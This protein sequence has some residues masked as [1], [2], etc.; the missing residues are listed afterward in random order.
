MARRS[1]RSGKRAGHRRGRYVKR[2]NGRPQKRKTESASMGLEENKILTL[3]AVE[4][5]PMALSEIKDSLGVTRRA[6]KVL[7]SQLA[8]L[9]REE[10]LTLTRQGHYELSESGQLTTG[11]ISMNPRGFGFVTP[12]EVEAEGR[13]AGQDIFIPPGNLETAMHGDRVLVRCFSSRRKERREGRVVAVLSRATNRLVGVF[14]KTS[15]NAGQVVPEDDRYPFTVRVSGKDIG[16][17]DNGDAVVVEFTSLIAGSNQPIGRIVEILGDPDSLV[18]QTEMTIRSRGLPNRFSPAVEEE[19]SRLDGKITMHK[20]RLDLREIPHVTIDGETARDFDDAVAVEVVNGGYRL[21]VSIADVSHYVRIGTALDREAYQRGTSVY[22]PNMVVPML[23][24][25]LSND[26]CSLVPEE[27]RYAFTAI[28]DFNAHGKRVGQTFH[29]SIIRSFHRLT[30]TKVKQVLVDHDESLVAELSAILPAL[31]TMAELAGHLEKMR[32]NRGSI[33]FE[34]PEAAIEIDEQGQIADIKVQSRN[35]AHKLIEEFMLAANEAVAESLAKKKIPTLYRIH[36]E[37]EA[38]KVESFCEFAESLGLRLPSGQKDPV[39]FGKVL[40]LSVGAP[41]EYVISNLL[42]RAMQQARYSPD[43]A[44]H[45]GLAAPFYTHFTSP[46]RR[47]PDLMVHRVL[48]H[49]LSAKKGLSSAKGKEKKQS[50]LVEAGTFLS[51]RERAAEEAE[52]E[53]REKM[54]V[55]FMA[56]RIGQVFDGIIA[57]VTSFGLFVELFDTSI[58]GAIAMTDLTDDYYSYD[59][60]N[61]RLVGRLSKQ[62]LQLGDVVQVQVAS[63]E[64]HRRRINFTLEKKIG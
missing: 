36:E 62:V 3:L 55:R 52:R 50:S 47:Y 33:G 7:T 16:P 41:K 35:M 19:V 27:D 38:Q 32:Q 39:W 25:R 49:L 13:D 61:H 63:V 43:N 28:L 20:D 40:E 37:P 42:L 64:V 8:S 29:K 48:V 51:Q 60:K 57:G 45:F 24:E 59:D 1:Q 9:C 21:Y 44:G 5:R 58:S 10:L 56:E 30:Y 15:R 17:T 54:K 26:L 6:G 14:S 2:G 4:G 22:F 23:P 12:R 31:K 11:I 46:I 53:V 18:V 34:I